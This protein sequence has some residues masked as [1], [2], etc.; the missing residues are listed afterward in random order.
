MVAWFDEH[1]MNA[2]RPYLQPQRLAE[3]FEREFGSAVETLKGNRDK[4]AD[5]SDIDDVPGVPLA[6]DRQHGSAHS[7]D[8]EKV[9]L[10]LFARFVDGCVFNRAR[11]S[12][13]GVVYQRVQP[14]LARQDGLDCAS[15][16][17][18]VGDV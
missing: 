15:H 18:I 4:A 17:C 16:G 8:A 6:H 13:S 3:T 12:K 7:Q 14:S 2:E 1:Y 10:E 9:H 11:N 5:G